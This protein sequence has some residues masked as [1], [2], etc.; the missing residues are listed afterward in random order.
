MERRRVTAEQITL[1]IDDMH[2]DACVRRVPQALAQAG[3]ERLRSVAFGRADL[4]V[5]GA[6]APALLAALSKAGYPTH[7]RAS[8]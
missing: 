2:C 8:S 3:A 7:V 4:E 6:D 5:Q 1:E